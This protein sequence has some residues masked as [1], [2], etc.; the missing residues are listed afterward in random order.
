M[1]GAWNP[2]DGHGSG[3]PLG[4]DAVIEPVAAVLATESTSI[5]PEAAREALAP[6]LWLLERANEGIGLTQTGALNRAFV[7]EVAERWPGWWAAEIFGP[8][9]RETDV[10]PLIELDDLLR[11]L[12]LIRRRGSRVASTKQGRALRADPPAL[13]QVLV[14]ELFEGD[15]FETACAELAAALLIAGVEADYSDAI[16]E[17]IRPTLVA[18]GWQAGGEPPDVRDI[19]LSVAAFLRPAEAIGL[20][21]PRKDRRVTPS[22]PMVLRDV[23]RAALLASLHARVAASPSG[24]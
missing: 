1:S 20:F 10:T 17:R 24:Q 2:T 3:G 15:G 18:E 22:S 5:H 13:L 8:P 11:R 21:K 23:G 4:W 16:P 6:T 9:H 12:R 14:N 7:R 19:G